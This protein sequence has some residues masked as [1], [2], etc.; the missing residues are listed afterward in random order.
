MTLSQ[1][2]LIT[3]M[4]CKHERERQIGPTQTAPTSLPQ[5]RSD[6]QLHGGAAAS[7]DGAPPF[8][9]PHHQSH[10]LVL[11]STSTTGEDAVVNLAQ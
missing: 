8:P 6:C 10:E 4:E 11:S 9:H 5:T 1:I 2:E 3:A 7:F